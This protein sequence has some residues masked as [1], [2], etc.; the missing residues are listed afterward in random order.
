MACYVVTTWSVFADG[1]QWTCD[2]HMVAN[3]W[4]STSRHL[5]SQEHQSHSFQKVRHP[6]KNGFLVILSNF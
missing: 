6:L 1:L 3:I 5:Y 4:Q 2:S